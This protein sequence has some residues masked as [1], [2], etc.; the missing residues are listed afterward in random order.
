MSQ[1]AVLTLSSLVLICAACS[2]PSDAGPQGPEPTVWI[3]LTDDIGAGAEVSWSYEAWYA[4]TA[5]PDKIWGYDTHATGGF[6]GGS[7]Q[8]FDRDAYGSDVLGDGTVGSNE[9]FAR[10]GVMLDAAFSQARDLGVRT[11]VGT[12]LP[13][14]LEP[15]GPEVGQA[16]VR[17]MPMELQQ[18]L[19]ERGEDPAAP[20]VVKAVYRGMF[21]RIMQTHP[22]DY[23]WLWT[24]EG[25]SSYGVN[26]RQI[27]A[28]L[29][30]FVLANEAAE[31]VEA[32]FELVLA[33][34]NV[35]SA[36]DPAEFDDALP[37]QIPFVGLWDQAAGFEELQAD[38]IKWPGT[39]LEED[40]G[41]SQPQLELRR[42]HA[43]VKAAVNKSCHGIIAKHWRTRILGPNL[44]GLKDLTWAYG[45]TAGEPS[46]AIETGRADWIEAAY[47]DW[48][49][50]QFGAE[51][52]PA[53]AAILA[54]LDNAGEDGA[55]SLPRPLG[56]EEGAPA[57]I[58][59]PED[60][61][62]SWA[63]VQDDYV[64]VAELEALRDS[65]QGAGN[66]ER[67]DYWLASFQALRVMGE[68]SY[69][70][71]S[72]EEDIHEERFSSALET[73]IAM[74][75][76]WEE[77]MG[78]HA[79]RATNA[80]DLGEIAG[81]EMV[82]WHQVMEDMWDSELARGLGGEVPEEAYPSQAYTGPA[83]VVVTPARTLG[84]SGELLSI[85]ALALGDVQAVALHLRP[86]GSG[87]YEAVELDHVARGV[88]T[89]TIG[90]LEE[91][92]EYWVE[93]QLSDGAA[94]FPA[95]APEITHTV[96]V[97]P[98]LG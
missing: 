30:D 10:T 4:H 37:P 82:T 93:A 12:E 11:A 64:F 83:R 34:W 90:P 1:H 69:L 97:L 8:L 67:F 55:G 25:W 38:R 78:L 95:A 79:R 13:L 87:E 14:G 26:Q 6:H 44:H 49:T 41:L 81:L 50:R 28:I 29:A 84:Y 17:G 62:G 43:D 71:W 53:V 74:A 98:D 19:Q 5:R 77:L 66:L 94:V 22:L 68:Y 70:R 9:L 7:D 92:V 63:Q 23:Y 86:M 89:T 85:D 54:E 60:E 35:G 46:L 65:V 21:E 76:M 88:W 31:Q 15:K 56:W 58:V 59:V 48:S 33:G 80:S 73:R 2:E 75:R 51:A 47:L 57:A 18:R 45:S 27:D 36:D 20:E 91:D 40:W 61:G 24:Y 3:G 32:P 39:W 16:W 96:V 72:F 52:G 42:L